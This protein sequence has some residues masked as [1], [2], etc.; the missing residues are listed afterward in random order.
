MVSLEDSG[1][2]IVWKEGVY[3]NVKVRGHGGL[4]VGPVGD[5]G[6]E[7]HKNCVSDTALL[8]RRCWGEQTSSI[9][10]A[11]GNGEGDEV[12]RWGWRYVAGAGSNPE[13]S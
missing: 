3:R 7:A 8:H 6:E 9:I 4:C 11:L 13:P 5:A 12:R 2:S 1:A 10:P